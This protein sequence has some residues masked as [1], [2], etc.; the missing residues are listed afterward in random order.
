MYRLLLVLAMTALVTTVSG[1]ML[2]D[3]KTN[4][5]L[6]EAIDRTAWTPFYHAGLAMSIL[7]GILICIVIGT[8]FV[9]MMVGNKSRRRT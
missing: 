7:Y 8:N 9:T 2:D 4:L 3:I 1:L 5:G 6:Y